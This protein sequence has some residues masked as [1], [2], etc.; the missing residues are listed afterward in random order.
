MKAAHL[1]AIIACAI[2][3]TLAAPA[4][5]AQTSQA[6]ADI[7]TYVV[8]PGDT[9][10]D[11]ATRYMIRPGDA[12]QVARLNRIAEPRRLRPGTTLRI[13]M[14]LLRTEPVVARLAAFRG[15][16]TIAG[17]AGPLAP[18]IGLIVPEGSRL[19]TAA[20]AFLTLEMPDGSRITLPSQSQVVLNRA[21]RVLLTGDIQRH[22]TLE[23]GRSSSVVNPAPTPGSSFIITT[24][25]TVS[26]V[27]GTEFR[28]GHD[29]EANHSTLEVV[30]GSVGAQA[31]YEPGEI[32][33]TQ[34]FG[35][36][37]DATRATAPQPLLPGPKLRNPGARQDEPELRFDV[38][39][40]E[41]AQ[42]YRGQL[43]T[44]AGF[45]DIL[46]ETESETPTLTF[47]SVPNA[48]YFLRLTAIDSAGLEGLP[49][50]YA[51][52]RRLNAID[53][54]PP[55]GL[56]GVDRSFLFRWSDSGEGVASFRFQLAANAEMDSPIIDEPGLTERQISVAELPDGV[57]F[58][59]VLVTRF[60]DGEA[61]EKWAPV[62]R[63]QLGG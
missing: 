52:E 1:A 20:G 40:A 53:L 35:R 43:A 59:R 28:V 41:G 9:L 48:V 47:A 36:R 7:A 25:L 62:Q 42:S 16:V 8:R 6:P 38:V 15:N 10:Y 13:P 33:V 4:A 5:R 34:A 27:R 31:S 50:V 55:A 51:I 22:L 24:P 37:A 60:E 57:Y 21:R 12:L 30:E 11:L 46:A 39:P 49:E 3:I 56:E 23:A 44:D 17:P 45:V 61:I 63:F 2:G 58:W 19:A 26:A 14:R 18:T 32:L 54:A 29:P